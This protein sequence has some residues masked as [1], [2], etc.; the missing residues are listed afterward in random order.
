MATEY[1][2]PADEVALSFLTNPTALTI[3]AEAREV[4]LEMAR[5]IAKDPEHPPL[6]RAAQTQVVKP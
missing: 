2:L 4:R 3:N 5:N 1:V 6:K